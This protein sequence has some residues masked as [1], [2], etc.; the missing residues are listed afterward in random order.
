MADST[1]YNVPFKRRR[2]QKTDYKRRLKL[3]KSGKPRA[4]VRTSNNHTRVHISHYER[5]G[6]RNEAQTL[7][8]ELEDHGWEHHTGNLPAAYLTGFL[9]G[10]KA[11]V[12]EAILDMGLR[13][14][15]N[16]SRVFAAVKGL[17]DAGVHVPAGE[18]VFPEEG[19]MRGEH[20]SEMTGEDVPENFE[21][22]KENI[23]G[24]Y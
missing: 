16:G 15:K 2:E 20:I 9:A 23:E 19:R 24:E 11:D 6:D 17:Q 13:E 4:V 10:M 8:K 18:E 22:V 7:S 5:E 12:E 21:E 3:L 1:N 14:K